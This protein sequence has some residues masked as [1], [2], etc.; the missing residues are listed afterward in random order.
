MER[1]A[2]K[3]SL[4]FLL[5]LVHIKELTT[6]AAVA[7]IAMMGKIR[8]CIVQVVCLVIYVIPYIARDYPNSVHSLD[9][10]HK[11]KKLKKALEEVLSY[12]VQIFQR[13]III[14]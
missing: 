1:L 8:N 13:C 12:Y 9:V 2:L 14:T 11:S 4:S 10:W 7:V 6:D 3:K 5:P